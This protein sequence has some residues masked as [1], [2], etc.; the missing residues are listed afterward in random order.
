MPSGATATAA[1][2]DGGIEAVQMQLAKDFIDKWGNLA[3]QGTAMSSRP[4][5]A[6]SAQWWELL[7]KS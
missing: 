7:C 6:T 2:V 5:S 3:K 4:T 1:V